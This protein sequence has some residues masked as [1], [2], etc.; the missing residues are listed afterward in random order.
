MP[1]T[2]CFWCNGTLTEQA[3]AYA[4]LFPDARINGLPA[5]D[6]QP[7]DGLIFVVLDLDGSP[8]ALLDGGPAFAPT[9]ALSLFVL[10]D[11]ADAVRALWAALSDDGQILMPLGE[12][13]WSPLYGWVRDRWGVTWQV[14]QGPLADTGQAVTPYLTFAGPAAGRARAA[15]DLYMRAFPG[16]SLDGIMDHDGS[17]PDAAGTVMHAQLRLA[18]GALMLGDSAHGHDWGFGTGV[19][20]MAECETQAE[21]DRLWDLLI[22]DGGAPSRCGWLTDPHGLS[23]QVLPA[24]L[25]RTM[26]SADADTAAR[27]M[28][29][30]MPMSKLDLATLQA[31]ARG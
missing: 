24:W 10:R 4:A 5:A 11:T 27:I 2:P 3:R 9:P 29:A 18:G 21:I 25:G 17:G 26:A 20:L 28:A 19:S 15:L 7:R 22:A 16:A 8:V 13:P 31:A 1:L 6:W 12:Y 14:A 23:W 30:F